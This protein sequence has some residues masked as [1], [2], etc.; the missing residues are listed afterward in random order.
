MTTQSFVLTGNLKNLFDKGTEQSS[1]RRIAIF[2]KV[3]EMA[4]VDVKSLALGKSVLGRYVRGVISDESIDGMKRVG[5]IQ[6]PNKSKKGKEWS[7]LFNS[8]GY[9]HTCNQF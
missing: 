2:D 1:D 6:S 5:D 4:G 8:F 9:W 3:S 7:K